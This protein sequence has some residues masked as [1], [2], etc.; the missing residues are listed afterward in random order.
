MI[1]EAQKRAKNKY[2]KKAYETILYR[3]R[4][5]GDI[6]RDAIQEAAAAAGLSVNEYITEAIRDKMKK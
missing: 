1:S 5:D 2:N 3:I 6:T 4:R